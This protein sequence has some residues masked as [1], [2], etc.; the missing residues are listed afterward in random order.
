MIGFSITEAALTGFR[1]SR[2]H[3]SALGL[4]AMILAAESILLGL[5]YASLAPHSVVQVM[6][7]W[8][9]G[10]AN[11]AALD[12]A[13]AQLLPLEALVIVVSLAFG[14]VFQAAMN[15]AILEPSKAS[16]GYLRLGMDELR[17]FLLLALLAVVLMAAYLFAFIALLVA[18]SLI[19]GPGGPARSQETIVIFGASGLAILAVAIGLAPRLSLASPL[20]FARRRVELFGSFSLTRRRFWPILA[21]FVIAALLALLVWIIGTLAIWA[22]ATA[23]H[24]GGEPGDIISPDL[25]SLSAYF[26]ADRCIVL[27]LGGGLWA[28]V[29]PLLGTP[30]PAIYQSLAPARPGD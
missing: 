16:F 14:A 7:A 26:T 8:R 17:Q 18:A 15:R 25:G 2:E 6:G 29:A 23:A 20:T 28:L 5:V 9:A 10:A 19:F 1:F 12:Q 27:I 13:V 22:L 21:A 24:G 4:W 11:A 3:P 30:A